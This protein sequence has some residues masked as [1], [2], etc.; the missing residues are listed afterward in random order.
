MELF[1]GCLEQNGTKVY[2]LSKYVDDILIICD[3][4][5]LGSYWNEQRIAWSKSVLAKHTE[6]RMSID[7]LK[8]DV[9]KQ[10]ADTLIPFLKFTGE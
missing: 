9:L 2:V 3:N 6:S 7:E 1:Q 8:L 10:I 5:R 4:V